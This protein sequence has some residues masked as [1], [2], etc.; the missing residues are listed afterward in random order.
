MFK[1][2]SHDGQSRYVETAVELPGN[3][4]STIQVDSSSVDDE[5]VAEIGPG[6][7]AVTLGQI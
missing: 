4:G 6:L 1:F 7:D 2:Y 5:C 3:L